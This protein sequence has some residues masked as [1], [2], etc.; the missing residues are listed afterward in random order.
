M[1][2][3]G[4]TLVLLGV[5]LVIVGALLWKT[6]GLGPFGKL[7]G[8]ISMKGEHFSFYFP[9]VTCIVISILLTVLA[10]LFRR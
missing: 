2:D 6:G 9:I 7:P 5:V 1:H 3:L 4:K 8:D 10:R